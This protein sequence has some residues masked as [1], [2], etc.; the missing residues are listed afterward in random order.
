[1]GATVFNWPS[2]GLPTGTSSAGGFTGLASA[3]FPTSAYYPIGDVNAGSM[4]CDNTAYAVGSTANVGNGG[5]VTGSVQIYSSDYSLSGGNIY[6]AINNY[7]FLRQGT[8]VFIYNA[9]SM[10]PWGFFSGVTLDPGVAYLIVGSVYGD[11][12]V[13]MAIRR[14][15]D[16]FWMETSSPTFS[17]AFNWCVNQLD[18]SPAIADGPISVGGQQNGGTF[19]VGSILLE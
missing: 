8:T 9:I 6:L 1:M 17:S 12:T 10:H 18:T 11:G 14:M 19:Q 2:S 3:N 4:T 16:G 7:L 13:R 15:T 5:V